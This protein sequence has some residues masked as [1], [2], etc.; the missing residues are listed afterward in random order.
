MRGCPQ[1]WVSLV[2]AVS[3]PQGTGAGFCVA[4][5]LVQRRGHGRTRGGP[6]RALWEGW[7]HPAQAG[8]WP[9]Q[10]WVCW[11]ERAAP[12]QP[13]SPACLCAHR[14]SSHS[15]RTPCAETPQG[16]PHPLAVKPPN[17][18]GLSPP[19][20]HQAE[21]VRLQACAREDTAGAALA[22]ADL[23]SYHPPGGLCPSQLRG[24]VTAW[25]Q[26][27][28]PSPAG[29]PSQCVPTDRDCE[30]KDTA[31]CQ[32]GWPCTLCGRDKACERCLQ[33]DTHVSPTLAT[34]GHR[35]TP[36]RHWHHPSLALPGQEDGHLLSPCFHHP[37][38]SICPWQRGK[39]GVW[40][41][42]GRSSGAS[43]TIDFCHNRM[44]PA[45][46]SLPEPG[47]SALLVCPPC[48][49]CLP[50][51]GSSCPGP[52][53]PC[54][55]CAGYSALS[56]GLG[57]GTPAERG[58]W[59]GR[60]VFHRVFHMLAPAVSP[61]CPHHVPPPRAPHPASCL[62]SLPH[63]RALLR[64]CHLSAVSPSFP[65]LPWH[66]LLSICPCTGATSTGF[67]LLGQ[68]WYWER[69]CCAPGCLLKL[70]VG[71]L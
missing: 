25:C 61:L 15:T 40:R 32:C 18:F 27:P 21:L 57:S 43:P 4:L 39:L 12:A 67:L 38:L 44:S 65:P 50:A 28:Q 26:G 7:L 11:V 34:P 23:M 46:S 54:H 16:Q 31:W 3:L 6:E 45:T 19:F 8:S 70:G 36:T 13:L 41:H 42:G 52:A 47:T 58:T 55:V 62:P 53:W 37:W 68:W 24:S 2:P 51:E 9:Q 17:P 60:G 59:W 30:E 35:D 20:A 22:W 56:L 63:H 71:W 64:L 66:S 69:G 14:L 33:L 10:H 1:I 48:P 5:G 29:S 49:Q